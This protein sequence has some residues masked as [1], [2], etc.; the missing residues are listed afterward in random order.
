V[1]QRDL[2]LYLG[3]A[4]DHGNI[5]LEGRVRV[6]EESPEDAPIEGAPQLQWIREHLGD[7]S[8]TE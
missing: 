7:T 2:K 1:V 5:G 4:A 3:V 8:V 6:A